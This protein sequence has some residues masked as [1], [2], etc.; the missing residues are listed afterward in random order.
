MKVA[1]TNKELLKLVKGKTQYL[2]G[3]GW[4]SHLDQADIYLLSDEEVFAV[5]EQL[6]ERRPT[7]VVY[8]EESKETPASF[9]NGLAD[10]LVTLPARSL[11]LERLFRRHA[12][13]FALRELEK[14]TKGISDLVH[15]LQEDIHLAEKIQRRL[16][17]EK[18]PPMSGLSVKSKYWCG[19]K[20]GGDY[21]DV[22]EFPDGNH[23]GIVVA[24]SST[25]A[26]SNAFIG[27]LMQFSIH[28]GQEELGDPA[29]IVSSLYGK[30]RE[31]MKEKD[32]FSIFYGILNR[33]TFQFRYVNQGPI[34][35]ALR[36]KSGAVQWLAK[37]Q[38]TPLSLT[39]KVVAPTEEVAMEPEDRLMIISDGWG[40]ALGLSGVEVV[41][42]FL[43]KETDPQDLLNSMAF[44][45]KKGVEKLYELDEEEEDF[46]MPPQDCSILLFEF[47]R[48]LLRLAR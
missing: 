6:G 40:E 8:S 29:K 33:K 10:D 36:S 5:F 44:D 24:D 20:A 41:E 32:K 48:N 15:R 25:Y 23:V 31:N 35:S 19:L 26:L 21:F 2:S 30:V 4:Q 1:S 12:E 39:Q 47:A 17:K 34:F 46:P 13:L 27:S 16:I 45:L 22:F 11:D 43:P 3:E 28:V 42:K 38:N 9:V 14:N 7:I 18:F 37:G